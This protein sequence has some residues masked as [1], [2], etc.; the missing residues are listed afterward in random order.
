MI[1][2]LFCVLWGKKV[3][4]HNGTLSIDVLSYKCIILI[5]NVKPKNFQCSL[6]FPK[7][8]EKKYIFVFAFCLF[9]ARLFVFFLCVAN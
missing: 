1:F 4:F 5:T 2:A 3:K 7:N 8:E 6:L 9:A